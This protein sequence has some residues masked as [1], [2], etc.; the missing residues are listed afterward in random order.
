M[1]KNDVILTIKSQSGG[2]WPDEI[3]NVHQKVR[4][5]LSESLAHFHLDTSLNYEVLLVRSGEQRTLSPDQSL[6]DAG[7]RTGDTLM[8]RTIGRTID[9]MRAHA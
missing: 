1:N 9:G 6:Q 7:V 8:V 4:H 3:F 5:L 2:T